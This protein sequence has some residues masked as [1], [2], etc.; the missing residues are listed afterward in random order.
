MKEINYNSRTQQFIRRIE[1]LAVVRSV[2][3]ALVNMVP[4]LMIGAFALIFQTLPLPFYQKLLETPA[5][6]LFLQILQLIYSGTFGVLSVYMTVLISEAYMKLKADEDG[7]TAG[8][9]LSSLICFFVLAGAYLPD[10]STDCLG[11]KS[12]FLAILTGL[13]AS[14]LFRWLYRHLKREKRRIFSVGA[15]REFTKML[16]TLLP[17]VLTALFFT[18]LNTA[19]T[20]I[21]RVDSFR[22]GL[23]AL[24]NGLFSFGEVGFFKGFCFVLL[25]SLL[26]FFG[27]HGSDTLEGVMQTY[28]TPGLELNQAA[29]AAGRA[30][31][32]ILTKGFFDC[33][34]LMGGCGATICLLISI[35]LFSRNRSMRNLGFGAA[36]PM[37][38]NINEMM[39]FGLPVIFNP[40]MFIP[41]ILVPLVCYSAAYF[42][43]SSGLVPMITSEEAWTTPVLLGGYYATGSLA[44]SAL[45]LF[46]IALGV[47]IYLP[48]VRMLDRQS[49][50]RF[51]R[52]YGTFLDYY[53]AREQMTETARMTD[54]TNVFGE[55]A[56]ELCAELRDGLADRVVLGYQPQY[57]Y[58]GNCFGAEALLRWKHPILGIL[59]PPLVVR[60]AEEGGFLLELEEAVL[61]RVLKEREEVL[62]RFGPDIKISFNIT[63]TTVVNPR[64]LQYC[65]QMDGEYGFRGKNLCLE[66]TEQA[67]LSFDDGTVMA[68]RQLH[69]MGLMLAVDDFSMGQTSI[70]Y[71]KDNLFDVIK[72]DGSL[73][74]GLFSHQNNK[75]II[76]SIVGLANTLGLSIL[77]EFVENEEQRDTLHELGCDRYQGYLYSPAVFLEKKAA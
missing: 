27:I 34:V 45:Q 28:F 46:N 54:Q 30:P 60:L 62:E 61:E 52:E 21:A 36:F 51:K 67:A 63:G 7:N 37:I 77:A 8:A 56:R 44:G 69:D 48:F 6:G 22:I 42:A 50:I 10:F 3:N 19:I 38:F 58:E 35:L 25:S 23:N 5:G 39:V 20:R 15:D 29:A 40:L 41:F 11:P 2:R 49:E 66:V 74:R 1:Q 13:G 4:V 64:F 76:A 55:F 43:L 75:E 18:L 24:F 47:V 71:L 31:E 9:V 17:V 33:F 12:M 70:H 14:S 57:D 16:S 59:Y 53:K 32:V 73:V 72:L 65:V 26:W 68:L